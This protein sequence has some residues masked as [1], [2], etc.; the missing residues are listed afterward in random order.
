MMNYG[1]LNKD[2]YWITLRDRFLWFFGFF[3]AGQKFGC[4]ITLRSLT[5]S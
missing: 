4:G 5:V 1:D 2:A 3:V